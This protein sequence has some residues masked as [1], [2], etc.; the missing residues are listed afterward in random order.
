MVIA[1]NEGAK[2]DANGSSVTPLSYYVAKRDAA[3][4]PEGFSVAAPS[5][6]FFSQTVAPYPYEKLA[7]IVGAT[8]FGGMEN[9]SAIVFTNNLFDLR[10]NEKMSRRFG[11]PARIE[12]VVAH[13][14]AHQWFGDSVTEATWADL[15]LSEGFAT[16]F[17]GLFI[18]KHDCADAFREYMHDAAARYFSYEKKRN[19]PI[20]D[21]ETQD[22]MKLL[23][24]NN[25]EKGAWVLHML[26]GRLGDEAFFKGLRD[27]YNAHR[28]AN[29]TTEDLRSALEK[30]SGKSLR[31][32]F[33]RWVYGSGHPVYELHNFSAEYSGAGEFLTI[34]LKQMQAGA[35]FL[36]PVTIEIVCA[37]ATKKRYT[38]SPTGKT[39]TLR[40][41]LD[42]FATAKTINI[43]PDETLLKE[44]A[45]K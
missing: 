5:L 23:N 31:E 25:Y 41:H 14:I 4:A 18:E 39:A 22:L 30:A 33:A 7:L 45:S 28:E 42:K 26:R 36:D 34:N 3:Y 37:D 13:E 12:S 2:I 8:R 43:D 24:E 11:I 20:H 6:L 32:F 27:Y 44:A 35:A 17:A 40:V 10:S 9:S 1:V 21:T 19:A 29:A 16:Y 38:I 15:W